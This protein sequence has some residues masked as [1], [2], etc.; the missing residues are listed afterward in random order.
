MQKTLTVFSCL[1]L[2]IL[3][4]TDQSHAKVMDFFDGEQKEE[5]ADY[6]SSS[7]QELKR[8]FNLRQVQEAFT[9]SKPTENI[10]K[11][12]YNPN[13]IYKIKTRLHTDTLIYLPADEEIMF[14]S[15][16][17]DYVFEVNVFP[18]DLPN[19]IRIKSLYSGADT[20]LSVISKSGKNYSFY[21]R[22][23]GIKDKTLPDLAVFINFKEKD[24]FQF[25]VFKTKEELE[26][27]K[28]K[29]EVKKDTEYNK[30]LELLKDL[31]KDNDYLKSIKDP[32]QINIDY[33][34]YGNKEIA[35][36]GVYDDGKWTYFDFRQDFIS[37]RLPVIYKVIDG[38]DSVINTRVE[39]G[40]LI[41]ESLSQKWTLKNGDKSVCV[42]SKT[43]LSKR[44]E[45][46]QK[47]IEDPEGK[48]AI[49]KS[50]WQKLT[51]IFRKE[52]NEG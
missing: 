15:L 16:G 37:N 28:T 30:R 5:G 24:S 8:D 11:F 39:N 20:S 10:A 7:D 35:P 12:T 6:S 33:R 41:A 51:S 31:Q 26:K 25:V 42:E 21:I 14:Y 45:P 22:S 43:D 3:I 23:Y 44:Y 2:G 49:K 36:F 13:Q 19:L 50:V 48:Q 38:Y 1:F 34:M 29:Q 17:D 46:K 40:F 18:D 27:S 4:L 9:D 32:N 47:T 52:E